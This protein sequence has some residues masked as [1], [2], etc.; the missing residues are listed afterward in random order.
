[1]NTVEI[2]EGASRIYLIVFLSLTI[3]GII[4]F[5]AYVIY[6]SIK[7]NRN[8][9]AL[10][11]ARENK[12][13]SEVQFKKIREKVDAELAEEEEMHKMRDQTAIHDID[14]LKNMNNL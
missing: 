3:I 5:C 4:I 1:M 9:A 14:S 7:K 11:A 10:A 6:K 2:A 8:I 13:S 12:M